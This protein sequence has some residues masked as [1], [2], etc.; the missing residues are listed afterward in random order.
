MYY[1]MFNGKIPFEYYIVEELLL[2]NNEIPYDY[3]C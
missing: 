3:K 2:D 1:R